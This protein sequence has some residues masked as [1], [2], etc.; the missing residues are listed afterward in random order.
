MEYLGQ[1]QRDIKEHLTQTPLRS[2]LAAE[3]SR[4]SA[5]RRE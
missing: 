5:S 1:L 3:V 2:L 4:D